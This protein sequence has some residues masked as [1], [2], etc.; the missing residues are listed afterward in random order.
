[1]TD[2]TPDFV[3]ESKHNPY[4]LSY[5]VSYFAERYINEDITFLKELFHAKSSIVQE[6]RTYDIRASNGQIKVASFLT[7]FYRSTESSCVLEISNPYTY[8]GTRFWTSFMGHGKFWTN[9]TIIKEQGTN[10]D[11]VFN[12]FAHNYNWL[13]ERVMETFDLIDRGL[14]V[15]DSD[16]ALV[17]SNFSPSLRSS[18]DEEK[19]SLEVFKKVFKR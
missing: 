2:P 4:E 14:R 8:I 9:K 6:K 15:N 10:P 18:L 3:F 19:I 13:F 11:I 5:E 7:Q 1:M 16:S 12:L 17:M